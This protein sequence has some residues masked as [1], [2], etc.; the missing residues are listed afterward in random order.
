MVF[1]SWRGGSFNVVVPYSRTT[2]PLLFLIPGVAFTLKDIR[3]VL[4]MIGIAGATTI[5]VGLFSEDFRTGRLQLDS[6]HGTIQNANDFATHI[7][8]VIPA[9]AYSTMQRGRNPFLKAAGLGVI[10]VGAYELVSTGSRGGFVAIIVTAIYMFVKGSARMKMG[11]LVGVPLLCA[12]VIPFA[13]TQSVNRILSVFV[14]RDESEEAAES[15]LARKQLL[16]TSLEITFTHPLLGVG[17][18]E[19]EDYQGGVAASEGQRGLWHETHNAYTQISSE[20]GIPAFGFYIAGMVLTFRSLKRAI[21]SN[22]PPIA[23]MA[24]TLSI[25]FVGYASCLLFLSQGYSFVLIVLCGLSVAI[26]RLVEHE[27]AVAA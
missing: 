11:L 17:P 12:I 2:L 1:S 25:M 7:I 5:L 22:N 13:P 24:R 6:A 14:S 20:V 18:G 16:M 15:R 26:E 27:P 9:I 8:L 4:V 21:A 10:M 3:K 23:A 19:F